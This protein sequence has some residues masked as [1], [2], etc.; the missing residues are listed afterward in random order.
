M[1]SAP[2]TEEGGNANNFTGRFQTMAAKKGKRMT[3]GSGWRLEPTKGRKR[4][5]KGT[6]LG[7]F[8]MGKRRVAVFSVPKGYPK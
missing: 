1:A 7:T 4:Q 6:L 5:F 2:A 8:N 3:T